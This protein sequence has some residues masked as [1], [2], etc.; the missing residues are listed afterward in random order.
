MCLHAEMAIH[1]L[2]CVIFHPRQYHS[3]IITKTLKKE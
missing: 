3:Y 2:G 1:H